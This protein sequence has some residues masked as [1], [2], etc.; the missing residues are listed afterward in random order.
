MAER[1]SQEKKTQRDQRS[2]GKPTEQTGSRQRTTKFRL[3]DGTDLQLYKECFI[4]N[5]LET[6]K[7][8][9]GLRLDVR[10]HF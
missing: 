2:D 4:M 10:Q 8:Q 6:N 5:H 7:K 1:Q 9:T 3:M